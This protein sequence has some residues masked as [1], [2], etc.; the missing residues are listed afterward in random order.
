MPRKK[1]DN[2]I[3]E[4]CTICRSNKLET[5]AEK[6][7][8]ICSQCNEKLLKAEPTPKPKPGKRGRRGKRDYWF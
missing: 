8:L 1:A 2:A 3:F 5:E 4:V 7:S 6:T